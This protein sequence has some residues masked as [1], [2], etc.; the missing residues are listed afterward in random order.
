MKQYPGEGHNSKLGSPK[1]Q[2]LT[3]NIL[4]T[5]Q[6]HGLEQMTVTKLVLHQNSKQ[7]FKNLLTEWHMKE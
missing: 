1:L 4:Q 3:L 5:E 7:H 2:I 6:C